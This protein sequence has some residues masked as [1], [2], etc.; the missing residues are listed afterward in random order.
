MAALK[1][2][3]KAAPGKAV[4]VHGLARMCEAIGRSWYALARQLR[5]H[6]VSR[7]VRS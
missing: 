3:R 7:G 1:Q 4:T 5:R 2:K 6:G